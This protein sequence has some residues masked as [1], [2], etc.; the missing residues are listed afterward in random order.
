MDKTRLVQAYADLLRKYRVR[1][2]HA[3]ARHFRPRKLYKYLSF[4]SGY[5]RR[6]LFDCEIPFNFPAD[7]NDPMDSRW[8]ID[9][10]KVL[11]ERFHDIGEVW[12]DELL[13]GSEAFEQ[14]KHL[15]EE[16]LLYLRRF[17]CVSCFSETPYSGP[18]WGHYANK[19]TGLCIEYDVEKL[20]G[21]FPALMPVAY[22]REPFDASML[23]DM[24]GVEQKGA[25]LCPWLF[26]SADWA[27]EREWRAFIPAG[28]ERGI[29]IRT[30][31]GPISGVYFGLHAY[32]EGRR[33]AESWAKENGIPAYQ[34]ER[35]YCSYDFISESTAEIRSGTGPKGFLI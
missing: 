23:L 13:G 12:S 22:S 18:M 7:F 10:E 25:V 28:E 17:F 16:D 19:H 5:W 26:K 20:A 34:I 21:T 1:E 15:S 30:A 32:G 14:Y 4:D 33:E 24:R 35:S 3:V 6:D 27:Y 29:H 8:F 2:A 31:P 9:Y 11:R